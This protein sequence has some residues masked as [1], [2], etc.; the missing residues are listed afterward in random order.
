MRH[1]SARKVSGTDTRLCVRSDSVRKTWHCNYHRRS[2]ISRKFRH[3]IS[4][5]AVLIFL[6]AGS[7]NHFAFDHIFRIGNRTFFYGNTVTQ[8]NRFFSKCSGNGKFII[9]KRC[10]RRLETGTNLNRRIHSDA[11]RYWQFLSQS[12]S[13]LCHRSDMSCSRCKENR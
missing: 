11:D 7:R 12:F 9:A 1:R 13:P 10:C 3:R 4:G 6:Y 8:N 5:M 2:G